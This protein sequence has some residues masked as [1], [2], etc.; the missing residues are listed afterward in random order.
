LFAVGAA[1]DLLLS[2]EA[3]ARDGRSMVEPG[4]TS[5]FLHRQ[6]AC[7]QLRPVDPPNFAPVS[8]H[9][10][11]AITSLLVRGR[12]LMK[13]AYSFVLMLSISLANV[14]ECDEKLIRIASARFLD[15]PTLV[16]DGMGNSILVQGYLELEIQSQRDLI[17]LATDRH[18]SL[19][20]SVTDCK[21]KVKLA[22]FPYLYPRSSNTG[23]YTYITVVRYKDSS[24]H[25]YN[26][27][28]DRSEL[29]ITVGLG[30][31]NL[32]LASR[33]SAPPYSLDQGIVDSLVT[34]SQQNGQVQLKLSP[35]CEAHMCI[36]RPTSQIQ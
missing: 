6:T 31:M 14:G 18:A 33:F 1:S 3:A 20:S 5:A 28:K 25:G 24:Q 19:W 2:A 30:T 9:S 12:Q 36:P 16:G 35:D 7:G 29:C 26:L 17:K 21:S 15:S 4:H 32:L 11:G 13:I 22:N 27:A 8:R 10:F 34:Y 23:A